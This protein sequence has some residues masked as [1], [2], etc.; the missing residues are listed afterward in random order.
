MKKYQCT[1][2]GRV[3]WK[4]WEI[5]ESRVP[6][7]ERTIMEHYVRHKGSAGKWCGPIREEGKSDG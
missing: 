5:V 6:C 4:R 2:C 7:S 3:R 1:R